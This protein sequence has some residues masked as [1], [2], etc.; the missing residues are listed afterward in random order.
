MPDP[1][2]SKTPV[3]YKPLTRDDTKTYKPSS[4]SN[5]LFF[6]FWG[7]G[8]EGGGGSG[9]IQHSSSPLNFDKDLVY[10]TLIDVQ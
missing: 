1:S 3:P 4:L 9:I 7:G 10:L 5:C 8:G 6:V 2:S